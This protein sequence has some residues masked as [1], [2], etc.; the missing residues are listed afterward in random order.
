MARPLALGGAEGERGAPHEQPGLVRV[1]GVPGHAQVHV[2][3]HREFAEH[4]ARA[5]DDLQEL[6]ERGAARPPPGRC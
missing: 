5:Q 2:D 1:V 3:G 4:H 6:D